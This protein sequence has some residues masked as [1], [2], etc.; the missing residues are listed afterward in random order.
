[1]RT[2]SVRIGALRQV[3]PES[4]SFYVGIVANGTVC[5]GAVLDLELVPARASCCGE[6]WE[7]P[8]FRCASC[9]EPAAIVAGTEFEV[10]SIVIE[11]EQPCIEST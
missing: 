1:V 4:L 10:E 7:P 9:G 6:E 5:E 3:V 2:I 11:E 8:A